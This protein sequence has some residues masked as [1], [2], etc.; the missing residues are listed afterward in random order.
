MEHRWSTRKPFQQ[1]VLLDCP[2]FGIAIANARDLSYG[3]M[4]VD[5]GRLVLPPNAPVFVTFNLRHIESCGTLRVEAMVVRR[6]PSGTGLM[7]LDLADDTVRAFHAV[8]RGAPG[9]EAAMPAGFSSRA[10]TGRRVAPA[11]RRTGSDGLLSNRG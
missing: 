4:F 11:D 5:T 8:L 3:G 2:H 9:P 1:A 6:A 10:D 7:F